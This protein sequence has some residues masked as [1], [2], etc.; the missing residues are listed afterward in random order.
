MEKPIRTSFAATALQIVCLLVITAAPIAAWT[1]HTN[2]APKQQPQQQRLIDNARRAFVMTT[3]TVAAALVPTAVQAAAMRAV[4]SGE[5]VCREAGNCLEV[6]EWD[7]AINWQWGGKDRCDA[8]DPLCGPDGKLRESAIV[9]KPVPTLVPRSDSNSINNGNDHDPI[10]FTHVAAIQVEVGRGEIGVLKLG[11]YGSEAPEAVQQL[12]DFLSPTGLSGAVASSRQQQ[13]KIGLT[14]PTV[15]LQ[16]G[17]VV[18]GIVPQSTVEFGV[19]SQ[20][21]AF[22]KSLGR[23]KAGDSFVPQPRPSPLRDTSIIRLHDCAGLISVP[24]QGLG[25]GGSGFESNDK[26]YESAFLITAD[27]APALDNK[28]SRV[29]VGQVLDAESMAFLERL[30]NVPTKRG[31]R[32]VI[33]GQTSGPPLPKV[34]V[35]QV[36]VS[37]VA[38]PL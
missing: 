35:R 17:G 25:Y 8:T 13:S 15:S 2:T 7:G 12:V 19:P 14:Q 37:K 10:R 28:R 36:Q 9:G 33:P 3:S 24:G 23:S 32:G 4:G 16:N 5:Q 1:T 20:A 27:A 21:G 38:P 26:C 11:F 29:V 6:G 30:A 18:T 31:I 22:A 34:V